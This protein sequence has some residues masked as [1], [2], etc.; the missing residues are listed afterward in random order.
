MDSFHT[1]DSSQNKQIEEQDLS[2]SF[3]MILEQ[4]MRTNTTLAGQECMK[5]YTG[6]KQQKLISAT[7]QL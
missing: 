4:E 1:P 6:C 2:S 5:I 3:T 7:E